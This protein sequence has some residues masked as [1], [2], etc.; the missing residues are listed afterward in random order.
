MA[1]ISTSGVDPTRTSTPD[2][3]DVSDGDLVGQFIESKD[4][5]AFAELVRRHARMVLG[6]CQ[7]VLD[8]PHDAEDCFQAAF[9]VLVRKAATIKPRDMVGNW[10]Y[11]VAYRTALEARKM[12][13]RRRI[14]EKKKSEM[15][16]HEAE[17]DLW[18]DLRPILD[19]EL[20]RLPDKYRAVLIA[21]DVEGRTRREVAEAFDLP[22]GTIASRLSR[23]R[24]MLAKRLKRRKMIITASMVAVL[25]AERASATC[26]SLPLV[27]STLDA[28]ALLAA[29]KPIDGVVRASVP[30]LM[31]AVV[32]TMLWA[33]L[34]LGSA[35]LVILTILGIAFSVILPPVNAQRHDDLPK[36]PDVKKEKP[37]RVRDCI[38]CR[39]DL[40]QGTIQASRSGEDG[41]ALYEL[42]V[43]EATTILING[44]DAPLAELSVGAVVHIDFSTTGVGRG[45][46][47]R[48]ETAGETYA[49]V[50]ATANDGTVTI[51][52]NE[53]QAR[54]TFTFDRQAEVFVDG[55]KCKPSD[56]KPKMRVSLQKP[57]GKPMVVS[58]SA[59]GPK[60]SGI[61]KA[62]DPKKRTI[63]VGGET[64]SVSEDAKIIVGGKT[65][66]LHDV[67]V[68]AAVTIQMSAHSERSFIVAI[69]TAK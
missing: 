1:S 4:E 48:I 47:L 10:L 64:V 45:R 18:E 61:V 68:G 36:T 31:N 23:G 59:V 38:V 69:L 51:E 16:R 9:M 30:V 58:A 67:Q 39:V 26:V 44:K 56:L 40:E 57:A 35:A 19:Q 62:I 13:A 42:D 49:G 33:K 53:N 41:V 34:T 6:V 63:S 15:P 52:A 28:A 24:D 5:A 7:R 25:L 29:G 3:G 2:V 21:C 50:I 55:K 65:R 14:R 54:E 22:E 37:A 43:T 27:E 66:T 32:K 12:T 46:I 20:S 60:R 8:N 17:P 11:G